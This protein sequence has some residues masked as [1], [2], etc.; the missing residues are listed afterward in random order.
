MRI[1][2]ATGRIDMAG[3]DPLLTASRQGTRVALAVLHQDLFC[4]PYLFRDRGI[5]TV[6]SAGDAGDLIGAIL[7]RCGFDVLRG[8]T[9]S[10]ASR[11]T[12]IFDD[13]VARIANRPGAITAV[14]PDGSRGPAGAVQP[15]IALL[16]CRTGAELYCLKI[17]AR[18]A[19]YLPTWDRTM[20]PLPFAR[21]ELHFSEKLDAPEHP[22]REE[23]EGCRLEIERR[24]HELHAAAFAS[25]GRTPVPLLTALR[26][27]HPDPNLVVARADATCPES[28]DDGIA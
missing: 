28:N 11:R 3:A 10:R 26:T 6:A 8:G 9:S 27:P 2:A 19:L 7:E 24:L 4:C 21:I 15:G 23:L 5:V 22:R 17:H 25:V 13:L 12:P 18:P 1:V 14:T 16:A 20:I